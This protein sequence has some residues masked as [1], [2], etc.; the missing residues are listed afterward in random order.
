MFDSLKFMEIILDENFLFLKKNT[1]KLLK[2]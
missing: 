1:L 2:Y